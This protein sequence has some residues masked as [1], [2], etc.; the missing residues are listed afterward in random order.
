MSGHCGVK[1][2]L[3]RFG[4]VDEA[5]CVCLEDYETVDHIIWNYPRFQEQSYHLLTALH[6]DGVGDETPM[7]DLFGQL[8]W[9]PMSECVAFLKECDMKI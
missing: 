8:K 4:I 7:R 5:I 1:S 6:A 9:L 3:S 2:H